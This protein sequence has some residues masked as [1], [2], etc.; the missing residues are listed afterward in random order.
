M[1]KRMDPTRTK[2]AVRAALVGFRSAKAT[3]DKVGGP[4]GGSMEARAREWAGELLDQIDR[5][6]TDAEDEKRAAR[7]EINDS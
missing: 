6:G 7:R 2:I 5:E 4:R 3:A 1:A